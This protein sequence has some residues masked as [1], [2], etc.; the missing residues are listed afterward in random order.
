MFY[1]ALLPCLV[2]FKLV[3]TFQ[4]AFFLLLCDE[5]TKKTLTQIASDEKT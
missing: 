4:S 3:N 1:K 5:K 2:D